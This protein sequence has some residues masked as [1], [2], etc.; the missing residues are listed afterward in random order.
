MRSKVKG[1]SITRVEGAPVGSANARADSWAHADT[2]LHRWSE[3]VARD[4]GFDKCEFTVEW[5]D[6][7][8]YQ[9]R[10]DL[11]NWR[12]A[13]P[14]LAKH[15]RELAYFYTGR[16]RPNHMTPEVYAAFLEERSAVQVVYGGLLANNDLGV[17][18]LAPV[19]ALPEELQETGPFRSPRAVRSV[20]A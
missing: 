5:E 18:T 9:G 2:V 13:E 7:E 19:L 4:G 1:I 14:D 8:T 16:L 11:V 10:F 12:D 15:V 6:G 3:S 20:R 17:E